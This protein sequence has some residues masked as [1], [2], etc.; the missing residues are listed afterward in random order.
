[1][2]KIYS[3]AHRVIVW[4]GP[5]TPNGSSDRALEVLEHLGDQ[6]EYTEGFTL[7]PTPNT[8][9]KQ[10][11]SSG[12][13]ELTK[14]FDLSSP[15]SLSESDLVAIRLLLER[16]WWDRLWV[17]QEI[18]VASS[19]SLIQC[20]HCSAPWSMIRRG[21]IVLEWRGRRVFDT[22][23]PHTLVLLRKNFSISFSTASLSGLIRRTRKAKFS[24]KVCSFPS[25]SL[26]HFADRTPVSQTMH[27]ILPSKESSLLNA[28]SAL[29]LG[30]LNRSAYLLTSHLL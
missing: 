6:T 13:A 23:L 26:E 17:W 28:V 22:I 12:G 4:L 11:L 10:S 29:A 19:R 25:K 24:V 20:G 18:H 30:I 1:M 21:I 9:P 2:G 27:L 14:V 8:S 16:S 3:L 15:L 7:L 5:A